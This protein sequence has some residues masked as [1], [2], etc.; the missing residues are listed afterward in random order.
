MTSN[1]VE[2]KDGNEIHNK[3]QVDSKYQGLGTNVW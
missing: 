1:K 3:F 2:D